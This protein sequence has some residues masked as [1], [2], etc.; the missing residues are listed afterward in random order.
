M[1]KLFYK[2]II[3]NLQ[4]EKCTDAELKALLNA[5][6]YTVKKMDITLA[7][8]AWYELKDYVTA[9]QYRINLFTLMI[10]PRK[11]SGKSNGI[12]CLNTAAR[13]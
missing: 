7:H 6:E 13:S 10:E 2:A 11:S 3:E 1:S 12:A 9:K 8:K 4:N 5:F